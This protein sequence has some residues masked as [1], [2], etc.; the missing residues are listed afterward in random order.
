MSRSRRGIAARRAVLVSR[1]LAALGGLLAAVSL[2]ACGQMGPLTLPGA[3]E[4]S[5]DD[6][7]TTTDDND[8]DNDDN[9]N[10]AENER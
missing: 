1:L 7:A 8:N 6:S 4:A 2:S 10:G 9:N 5:G 3:T